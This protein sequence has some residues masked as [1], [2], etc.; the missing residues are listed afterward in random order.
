[1]KRS[2][3]GSERDARVA[4]AEAEADLVYDWNR[5]DAIGPFSA[6]A[7]QV[8]D[9]TLRDGIQSPSVV[10]P[11]LADK[12][13]LLELTASLGVAAA[14]IGL[15][16]AGPR[17]L[18]DVTALARH[19]QKRKLKL[20]PTCAARTV[21]ADIAP[22]A[23]VQQR[24]G[25]QIQAYTF[26]GSSPIRQF[27][28]GW[29]LD[30]LLRTSAAAIDFAVQH[31][32]EVCYVTEDTTRSRPETLDRLFRNAI[33]HG[34]SALCLC[35]TVGWATP[36][37]VRKLVQWTRSLARGM[38]VE[39]RLDWHGHNDRGLAVTNALYAIE[40]GADRVHGCALGMGE[41]VGNAALD[42]IL[43]NLKLLGAVDWDLK[44]LVRYVRK[45]SAACQFPI[46]RNYPLSGEDAFRTATGVH[47]AAIIKAKERGDY[48]LADRIYSSVPASWFGRHQ[49]IEIGPMSGMSNVN[50]WLKEHGLPS[51]EETVRAVLQRA[52]SS[53][54][55]LTDQEIFAVVQPPEK[56]PGKRRA[57]GQSRS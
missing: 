34:A 26:I 6:R 48:L 56:V 10:D 46:P 38:G 55:T 18:N 44:N 53:D 47:A 22:I 27:V 36:D 9:E 15:P 23:E 11:P 17:A 20:Q 31:G 7:F 33:D 12:M 41:R 43:L 42:L 52:K 19:I 1:M 54:R 45:A 30:H 4:P 21:T 24:A 16:G 3:N 32:L 14:N 29:D 5:L 57:A 37:G 49:T 40:Y 2:G 50:H 13:E 25:I 28:E 51:R 35:D 8:L 39:I